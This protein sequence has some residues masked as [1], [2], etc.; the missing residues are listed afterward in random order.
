MARVLISD[1]LSAA[2]VAVF[3]SRG[4][5]VDVKTGLSEDDL[6]ATIPGYDGLAVR[7]ATKVTARV[8]APF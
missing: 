6:I 8:L 5:P 7:S 2:A 4:I 1:A 3:E